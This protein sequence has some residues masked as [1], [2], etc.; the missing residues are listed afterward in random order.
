MARKRAVFI[1]LALLIV[2]AGVVYFLL[3]RP[4][5]EKAN[6]QTQLFLYC[7]DVYAE[8]ETPEG[9]ESCQAWAAQSIDAYQP[10]IAAC[11]QLSPDLK[12]PFMECMAQEGV[13]PP[14]A[15]SP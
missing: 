2:L 12:A 9:M 7:L 10:V 4:R 5:L 6:A 11:R 15:M 1:G 14:D 3:V 8:E 13:L